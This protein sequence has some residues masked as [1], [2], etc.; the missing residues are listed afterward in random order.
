VS[1]A[2]RMVFARFRELGS[3]RQ[4]FLWARQAGVMLPV[5]QRNLDVC[6]IT[7]RA[8]AYHSVMRI[9]R[10]PIY[11]GAYAFARRGDRIRVEH[12]RARKTC[13]HDRPM[14]E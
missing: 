2:I 3:A 8:P 1:G 6:R 4:V 5:V 14:S 10:S 12:G 13:G 7:W 9:L 11:A